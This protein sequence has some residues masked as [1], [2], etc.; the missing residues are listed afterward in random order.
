MGSIG[1][2]IGGKR[3]IKVTNLVKSNEAR[4]TLDVFKGPGSCGLRNRLLI[5]NI[6][7]ALG[8]P[9]STVESKVTCIARS[10]G[11]SNLFLVRSVGGGVSTTGLGQVTMGKIVGSGRRMGRAVRCGGSV[12]VGT[13]SLR[14]IIN[15]LDKKGRRG[16]SLNG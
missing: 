1:F 15:G 2:R 7:G 12:C 13:S 3:V 5:S 9:D 11:K 4:L 6:P 14:R 10:Q 16:I 8:R